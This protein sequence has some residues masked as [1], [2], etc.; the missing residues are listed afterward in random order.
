MINTIKEIEKFYVKGMEIKNTPDAEK[1]FNKYWS[2]YNCDY[3]P[4]ETGGAMKAII[5]TIQ[6]MGSGG[7]PK[8]K[9]EDYDSYN[10]IAVKCLFV[11]NGIFLNQYLIDGRLNTE[12]AKKVLK[13]IKE[14]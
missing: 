12:N 4:Q 6:I 2:N 9:C 3:C 8:Y 5:E 1:I 13:K 11:S 10:I 14:K 7:S